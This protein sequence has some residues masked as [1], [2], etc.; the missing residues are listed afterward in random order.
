[1][2]AEF[3]MDQELADIMERIVVGDYLSS[4]E[5]IYPNKMVL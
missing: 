3:D 2:D 4:S 5:L 1:M